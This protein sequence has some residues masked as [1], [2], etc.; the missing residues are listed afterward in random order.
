[1]QASSTVTPH[2]QKLID[3]LI[4]REGGYVNDPDDR[5][6]PTKY[7]ITLATLHDWRQ[8]PVT[9][10]DVQALDRFEASAIYA[11]RYFL[12]PGFANVRD[13]L[14]QEFLFDFGV[15]SGPG[16]AVAALQAVIGV[17]PDGG[18]GPKTLAALNAVTNDLALFF[19]VKA[20]RY[21]FLLRDVGRRPTDA[22]YA[23]GWSNRLDQFAAKVS[24]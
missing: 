21:E 2:I 9:A 18:F 13:P 4:Q 7:G 20:E 8:E 16:A 17:E 11:S 1:M 3:A 6:G 5:G 19:A 10:A 12:K 24:V 15:N 14:L 23:E 22:K